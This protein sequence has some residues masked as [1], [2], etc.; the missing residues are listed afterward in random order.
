MR[1]VTPAGSPRR[2]STGHSGG[3][4]VLGKVDTAPQ[5]NVL[6]AVAV[7]HAGDAINA[8]IAEVEELCNELARL[9]RN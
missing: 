9:R 1:S 8:L 5:P 3:L 4:Q 6:L 7:A 2:A